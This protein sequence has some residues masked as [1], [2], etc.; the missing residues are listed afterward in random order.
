M[1]SASSDSLRNSRSANAWRAA[2]RNNL[3]GAGV[4]TRAIHDLLV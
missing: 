3:Y 4:R 1:P 2:A